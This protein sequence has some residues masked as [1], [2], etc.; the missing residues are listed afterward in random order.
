M[1]NQDVVPAHEEA[2]AV[3][4]AHEAPT[5]DVIIPTRNRG[6]LTREAVE[7]VRRQTFQRWRLLVVDDASTDGSVEDLR[8][9]AR[10]DPRIHVLERPVRGGAQCARQTGL[11]A[12]TAP[13]VA[14]LD[15][16]DLWAPAKLE[17]QLDHYRR[18]ANDLPD[19]GVVLCG[20]IWIDV[21]G[22]QRGAARRPEVH[23]RPSPLVSDN[24]STILMRRDYLVAAG[25]FLPHGQQSRAGANHID[26]Y[27]RMTQQCSFSAVPDVLV[28]CRAHE[29]IRDSD[30]LGQA[31]GADNLADLLERHS[32]YLEH[33]PAERAMLRARAAARYLAVGQRGRGLR[34]LAS[35]LTGVGPR[36]AGRVLR[37]Y[38]PFAARTLRPRSSRRSVRGAR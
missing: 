32:A 2:P 8:E 10:L 38:G 15:S 24:M 26:F 16:D 34:Y 9:L 1:S 17:R 3:F 30:V 33:Y 13:F 23:G 27:L 37:R 5:V 21:S 20:H 36:T 31:T 28:T 25:G 6:E 29:G 7:S 14:I 12:S 35:A 4:A 11:E 19:L 22:A 18:H